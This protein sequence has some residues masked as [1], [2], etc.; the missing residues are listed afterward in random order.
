MMKRYACENCGTE[1][2]VPDDSPPRMETI[3]A[4]PP[5]EPGEPIP[6][7]TCVLVPVE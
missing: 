5:P 6:A 1:C 2:M 7:E 3:S 4:C